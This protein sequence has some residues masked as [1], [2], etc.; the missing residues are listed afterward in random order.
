MQTTNLETTIFKNSSMV[1]GYVVFDLQKTRT[2]LITWNYEGD[3]AVV[4]HNLVTVGYTRQKEKIP[5]MIR[6]YLKDETVVIRF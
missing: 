5:Q 6:N 3:G 4:L 2:G 1:V